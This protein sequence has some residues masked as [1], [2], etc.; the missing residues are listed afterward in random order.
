[1]KKVNFLLAMALVA[2]VLLQTANAQ[3][4]VTGST[5]ANAS[6]ARLALAF[7]A[8]NG[9]AQTGNNIVI[10]ITANTT[11]SASAVLNAGAW[12]TLKIYPTVTGLSITGSLPSPLIDL[13][14][15]DNV[16]IDGRV[17]ATGA[18]KEIG[19]AHV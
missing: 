19:R 15:A 12:A 17:N 4:T 7:T 5:G 14:G 8:I 3:V 6:Y 18:T 10:T 9:T 11:E 16:T 1:M 2:L 13:N